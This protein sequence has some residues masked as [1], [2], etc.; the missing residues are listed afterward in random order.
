[1][2]KTISTERVFGK[3]EGLVGK[4]EKGK[5]EGEGNDDKGV[6]SE[7]VRVRVIELR[8]DSVVID[9]E[10]EGSNV[11]PFD[12]SVLFFSLVQVVPA[13]NGMGFAAEIRLCA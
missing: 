8:R 6:R 10:F 2:Y 9:G 4:L 12:V 5:G 7:L 3:Q 11:I 13:W 1:M